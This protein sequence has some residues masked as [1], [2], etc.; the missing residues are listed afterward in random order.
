MI[1]QD[2]ISHE[3][4]TFDDLKPLATATGPCITI[5]VPLPN[6]SEIDFG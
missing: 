6:P 4:V 3:T 2:V 1:A 5:S